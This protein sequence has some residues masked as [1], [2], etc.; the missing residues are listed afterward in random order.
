MILFMATPAFATGNSVDLEVGGFSLDASSGDTSGKLAA[1]GTYRIGY[2]RSINSHFDIGLGYTILFT[3]VISGDSG[4][5]LDLNG[6]YYFLGASHRLESRG[7]HGY[8]SYSEDLRPFVSLSFA[9][10]NYQSIQTSYAGFGVGVGVD[11]NLLER[12]SLRVSMRAYSLSAGGT[13]KASEISACGG[14]VI[15]F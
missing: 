6:T 3:K 9:Q 15:E 12:L 2:R 1:F 7:E 4:F 10:R 8:L 5:G 14:I 13:A 11:K